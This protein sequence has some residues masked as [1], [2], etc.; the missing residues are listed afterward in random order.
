MLL[1]EESVNV[2]GEFLHL[3]ID[4]FPNLDLQLL[5][6]F[7]PDQCFHLSF[8]GQVESRHSL[9]QIVEFRLNCFVPPRVLDHQFLC[10]LHKLA[11]HSFASLRQLLVHTSSYFNQFFPFD[12]LRVAHNLVPR[13]LAQ[14]PD[15]V[16]ERR[17][18]GV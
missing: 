4:K 12:F 14:D 18:K 6:V 2:G 1:F 13:K 16:V 7:V 5:F 9:L 3:V 15:L 10:L 11:G 17:L 8:A